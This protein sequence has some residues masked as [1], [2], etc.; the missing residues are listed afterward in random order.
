MTGFRPHHHHMSP[1]SPFKA[2]SSMPW[3]RHVIITTVSIS[4]A[5]GGITLKPTGPMCS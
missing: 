4:L 1:P 3:A 5:I 2:L